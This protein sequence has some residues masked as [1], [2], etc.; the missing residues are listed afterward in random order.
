MRHFGVEAG[1]D[2]KEAWLSTFTPASFPMNTIKNQFNS[3]RKRSTSELTRRH[4]LKASALTAFAAAGSALVRPLWGQSP[5][6][7]SRLAVAAIGCGAAGQNQIK[8]IAPGERLVAICDVDEGMI[9]KTLELLKGAPQLPRVFT[10]YRRMF[11]EMGG[12]IDV[13]AVATPDH[14]HALPAMRAMDAGI[15]MLVQKPLS[16]N[17]SE[18][19]YLA[20]AA[21]A[22][23]KVLTQ[24][25]NQAHFREG[26][27]R[28]CEYIWAGAIGDVVETHSIM[29]R[30]FGGSVTPPVE[31][32]PQGLNWDYWLGPAPMQDYHAGI[33][34]FKW[35]SWREFGAGSLGDMGC[36]ALDGVYWA[37]K[38]DL[39]NT[40]EITCLSQSPGTK[41]LF[42]QNNVIRWD[43]PPRA[44]MPALKV[45]TYDRSEDKPEIMKQ[46]EEQNGRTFTEGTLYIGTKGMIYTDMYGGG[47]RILPE[48]KHRAFPPP[49]PS[50]ER[51]KHPMENLFS[52]IRNGTSTFSSFDG[53]AGAYTEFVLTGLLAMAAGPNKT[54]TWDCKSMK[55]G[56]P[57]LDSL[58]TR[59][60][61]KPWVI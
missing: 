30:N 21:A 17:I 25:A 41:E 52:A 58:V 27:R 50:L 43:I 61:R 37:L 38:V 1:F 19:R 31:P 24:M 18:C 47:M 39:A 3:S 4:F 33:Q 48:E 57:A 13:V 9:A 7:N 46:V 51:L 10:D 2:Q 15:H 49:E 5:S 40:F 14:Q 59:S 42:T 11:D 35:R 26:Y 60:Y 54:V 32:I 34:P 8:M 55:T 36:H 6:P 56:D 45:F 23:P 22:H 12:E 20:E 29:S 44:G 16:N 28:L 53:F